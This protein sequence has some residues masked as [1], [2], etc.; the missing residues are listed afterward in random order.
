MPRF[1]AF[2]RAINVGGHN[3]T[4]EKLR[5]E[6]ESLGCQKVETFIASGNVIFTSASKKISVLEQRIE[7]QLHQDRPPA[8][9]K[10]S[11]VAAASPRKSR[12]LRW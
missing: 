7:G 4:M 3:V 5:R 1:I 11:Y 12:P 2:L 9:R 10:N 6:F 8:A